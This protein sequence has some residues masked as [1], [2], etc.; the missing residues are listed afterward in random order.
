MA[1]KILRL[2]A[3][4]EV[5]G[6]SRSTVYRLVSDGGFPKPVRLGPQSVGWRVSEVDEWLESRPVAEAGS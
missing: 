5:T 1:P 4:C 6:L 3:V 2:R